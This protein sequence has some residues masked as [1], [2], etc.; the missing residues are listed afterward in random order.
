MA[1]IQGTPTLS[2]DF[3]GTPAATITV[4]AQ[5][6]FAANENPLTASANCRLVGDDPIADDFIL[7]FDTH[8]FAGNPAPAQAVRFVRTNVSRA[9]LN[10]DVIGADEL[11]GE[12]ALAVAGGPTVKKRTNIVQ[13][14]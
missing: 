4:D 6:T 9:V 2:I 13:L 5:V 12:V 14:A 1:T 8:F 7:S 11:V 3:H 10:E